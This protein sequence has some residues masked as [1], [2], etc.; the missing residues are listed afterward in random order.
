MREI[1][2]TITELCIKKLD[3]ESIK[4]VKPNKLMSTYRL[5]VLT[6]STKHLN[7]TISFQ[8]PLESLKRQT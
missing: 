1:P 5:Y 2:A 4:S 3:M 7:T 8:T 6:S